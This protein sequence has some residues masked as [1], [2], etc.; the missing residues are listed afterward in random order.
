MYQ[1]W[2]PTL[3][4]S[5]HAFLSTLCIASVH[6]DAVKELP[7]ESTQTTALRQE[8]IHLINQNL[9]SANS[10]VDDF[11]I[12]AVTQL[13]AS[14]IIACQDTSLS[15]H[16]SGVE[17]MIKQ[18]GG[19]NQLGVNGLLA[20][21]ISCISLESA[22][23]HEEKSRAIYSDFCSSQA[24]K[25]YS[26]IGITPISPLWGSHDNLHTLR[27]S[28]GCNSRALDLLNDI[29]LMI[30][31]FVHLA[32]NSRQNTQSLKNLHKKIAQYPSAAELEKNSILNSRDWKYEVIR[33][34]SLI[35]AT[36]IIKCVPLSEALQYCAQQN[37]KPKSASNEPS[38]PAQAGPTALLKDLKIAIQNSDISDC[39]DDMA[40]V[41]LWVSLTV[42]AASRKSDKVLRQ[43]FSALVI[44]TSLL[45]CFQHPE[46]IYGTLLRMS[47]IIEW[48]GYSGSDSSSLDIVRGKSA[49]GWRRKSFET[50]DSGVSGVSSVQS[51][52]EKRQKQSDLGHVSPGSEEV[53][54]VDEL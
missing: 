15:L 4:K 7:N 38:V 10:Q 43:W 22:I 24:I 47:K 23:L 16:E 30:D 1:Y 32:K 37:P 51:A 54:P 14:E 19:L 45:L 20:S 53:T 12:I 18:R 34:A 39:W 25:P 9:A 31:L 50:V 35:Q 28:A 13:I 52:P 48:L 41:L 11:N 40:G 27:R 46:A 3:L 44:R 29:R 8:V 5:P 49:G 21:T 42:G 26:D 2:I 17:A 6:L 36:A 33:V